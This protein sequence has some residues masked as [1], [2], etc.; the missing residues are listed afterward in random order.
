MD[1]FAA[2]EAYRTSSIENAPPVKI[3]RML[4]AG[5]M[6][7]LEQAERASDDPAEQSRLLGRVDDIVVEL[8]LCLNHD[9]DTEVEVSRNLER[10]YLFCESELGAFLQDRDPVHLSATRSVLEILGDAWDRVELEMG[11]AA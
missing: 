11:D 6:R 1:R 10:L 9:V 2:A 5:A 4:Y 7:F 3:I 8:R